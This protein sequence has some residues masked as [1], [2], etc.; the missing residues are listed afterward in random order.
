VVTTR[1]EEPEALYEFYA[2]R[3]E[4]E[5]WIK[6]FKLHMKADRLICHR[7]SSRTSSDY[8]VARGGVLAYGR[9]EQEAGGERDARDA[10][11]HPKVFSDQDRREG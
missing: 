3:G 7:F 1:A 11:G 2:K 5:N 10:T 8:S 6:N 9:F 4:G